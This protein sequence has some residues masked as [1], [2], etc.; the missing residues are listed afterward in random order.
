MLLGHQWRF[1]DYS[2]IPAVGKGSKSDND[3]YVERYAGNTIVQV[4]IWRRVLHFKSIQPSLAGVYICAANYDRALFNQ[5]V[6]IQ[7][8]S[9]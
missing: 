8:T 9:E 5:S 3:V 6:E 4:P 2:R 1:D 7:V